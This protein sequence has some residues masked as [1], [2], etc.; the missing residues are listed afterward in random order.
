MDG[1]STRT[2][3]FAGSG[4]DWALEETSVGGDAL[5]LPR[6]WVGEYLADSDD[7]QPW[8][9]TGGDVPWLVPD[10]PETSAEAACPDYCL[11]AATD[12]EMCVAALKRVSE[13]YYDALRELCADR[14][15][16]YDV[17]CGA[18]PDCPQVSVPPPKWKHDMCCIRLMCRPLRGMP[19][20]FSHCAI[21]K[22]GC[23]GVATIYE[24]LNTDGA[25]Q[26]EFVDHERHLGGLLYAIPVDTERNREYLRTF[27]DRKVKCMSCEQGGGG[28]L[29]DP[30]G[31]IS[32]D[33]IKGYPHIGDPYG[34][35]TT[36]G[37]RP[38]HTVV[39]ASTMTAGVVVETAPRRNSNTFARWAANLVWA[40]EELPAPSSGM[41]GW[42][43]H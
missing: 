23:D 28:G 5:K 31:M 14:R 20:L 10:Y 43:E 42:G 38:P 25:S 36:A 29:Q 8:L 27:T 33:A 9:V 2:M 26:L 11:A 37:E 12:L 17:M 16:V 3:E 6:W 39:G 32:D 40:D 19:D 22:E 34:Y 15:R 7:D 35:P 30:C 18:F 24:L 41:W 1:G 4:R 13:D 21:L